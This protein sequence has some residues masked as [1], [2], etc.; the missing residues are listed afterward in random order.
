MVLNDCKIEND[1]LVIP[2]DVLRRWAEI[3][4]DIKGEYLEKCGEDLPSSFHFYSGKLEVVLDLL[5]HF[6]PLEG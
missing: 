5:K 2:R 1:C 6:E 3:Y 4:C